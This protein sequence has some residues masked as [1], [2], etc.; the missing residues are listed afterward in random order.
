MSRFIAVFLVLAVFCHRTQAFLAGAGGVGLRRSERSS[1][2]MA[3]RP[4]QLPTQPKKYYIRP[5]RV[6]DVLSSAPQILLRLGSGALVDGYRCKWR[7]CDPATT[8]VV[9][10]VLV[11]VLMML[12][13]RRRCTDANAAMVANTLV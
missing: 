12:C 3:A 10:R 2:R 11:A 5:D 7:R 8:A 4:E 1:L 9:V 13:S 6:L